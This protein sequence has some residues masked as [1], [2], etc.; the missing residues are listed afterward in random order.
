MKKNIPLL[1]A[2]LLLSF[3]TSSWAM[4]MEVVEQPETSPE[5]MQTYD[6]KSLQE[7]TKDPN[8]EKNELNALK[9]RHNEELNKLPRDTSGALIRDENYETIINKLTDAELALE[10]EHE[11]IKARLLLK[12]A[13]QKKVIS[14]RP[15]IVTAVPIPE[16]EAKP[17]A[18]EMT[19]DDK[20]RAIEAIADAFFKYGNWEQKKLA[21]EYYRLMR[22]KEST[23]WWR[24]GHWYTT[25]ADWIKAIFNMIPAE[26]F[27]QAAGDAKTFAVTSQTT[28]A[29]GA[30]LDDA[31]KT[32]EGLLRNLVG[33]LTQN[34]S[35]V[36]KA[37]GREE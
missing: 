8:W 4:G 2:W 31:Q 16:V 37:P 15:P 28:T 12:K 25:F 36:A 13:L 26:R 32:K 22:L 20:K 18:S 6:W 33:V 29:A 10:E 34:T 24:P 1:Q 3:L 23:S 17:V 5:S 21:V 9:Q 27:K 14:K 11:Q 19:P 30:A 35:S 7:R